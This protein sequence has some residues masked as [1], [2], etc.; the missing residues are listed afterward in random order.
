MAKKNIVSLAVRGTKTL[1]VEKTLMGILFDAIYPLTVA[2][3][4][5]QQ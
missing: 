3:N 4:P 2:I 1:V 5:T